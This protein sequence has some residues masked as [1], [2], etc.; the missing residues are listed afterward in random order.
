M[1]AA[2]LVPGVATSASAAIL[3]RVVG[4]SRLGLTAQ[5]RRSMT[6]IH[7]VQVPES[8]KFLRIL[9]PHFVRAMHAAGVEVH[10]WTINEELAMNRVLDLCVDGIMTDRCDLAF[11]VLADR[12]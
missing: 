7:A 11:R 9:T 2:H 1:R 6:G 8:V 3:R 5:V 4:A 12:V 10:V